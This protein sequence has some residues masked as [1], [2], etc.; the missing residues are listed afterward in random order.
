M[1][2]KRYRLP[3]QDFKRVYRDG[4]RIKGKFGM[5]IWSEDNSL[6]SPLF[7]FVVN[8][9]IGNSVKRHRL[10]RLLRSLSADAIKEFQLDGVGIRFEY[11]AFC[12]PD[13]FSS[14]KSEFLSQIK[15][16]C[17]K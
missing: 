6:S 2:P 11:I 5:L 16:A 10:V 7:G 3:A 1:I 14:L 4:K 17:L 12:F 13:S 15:R 8:K 9:K